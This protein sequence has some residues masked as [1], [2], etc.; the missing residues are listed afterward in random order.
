MQQLDNLSKTL[1][2]F[3]FEFVE[4]Q[5]QQRDERNPDLSE[6]GVS[7]RAKE[8]LDLQIL[9][10]PFEEKLDL[11]AVMINVADGFSDQ[12]VDVCEENVMFPGL[13]VPVADSPQRHRAFF[14]FGSG[15]DDHLV[16][17]ESL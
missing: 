9:L 7:A 13:R 8:G 12:M 16:G 2:Q 1:S 3:C 10:D 5:E 6:H 14:G 15:K 4:G 17:G 11:P